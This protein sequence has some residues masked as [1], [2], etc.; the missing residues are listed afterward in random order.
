M[1]IGETNISVKAYK[2]LT[3]KGIYTIEQLKQVSEK[4]LVK[5]LGKGQ[6]KK[7][8]AILKE[9][10]EPYVEEPYVEHTQD[11]LHELDISYATLKALRRNGIHTIEE[12]KNM[13][14]KE[15]KALKGIGKKR[16]AEIKKAL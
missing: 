16:F 2:I 13:T 15:L 4:R 3:K 12:L 14:D 11:N 9:L 5:I 6:A 1:N 7:V 10:E 8:L